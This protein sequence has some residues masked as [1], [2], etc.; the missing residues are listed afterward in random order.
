MGVNA[1]KNILK[2]FFALITIHVLFVFYI[3]N[4]MGVSIN[5]P[6]YI[7]IKMWKEIFL[8]FLLSLGVVQYTI[9]RKLIRL[10]HV[11]LV[12][13]LFIVLGIFNLMLSPNISVGLWSF[14]S[15][16]EIFGFYMLGRMFFLDLTQLKNFLIFI[17]I[18]G[19]ITSIFGVIQVKF[20]GPDFFK[21]VYG[22]DEVA[23]ALTGY[24]Y[25]SIRASSTFITPHEFG[26]FLVLCFLFSSYLF[27]EGHLKKNVFLVIILLLMVGLVLSLSR[28]S[29]V[30][31]ILCGGLYWVNNFKRL[32]L[33]LVICVIGAGFFFL[34]GAVENILSVVQGKDPSS[35]GRFAVFSEF[36]QHVKSHPFGSGLGTVGVVVRR[37]TPN[38]PQFEGEFFNLIAMTSFVGGIM[39]VATQLMSVLKLNFNFK[40]NGHKNLNRLILTIIVA[41][42]VRE[43]ILPRDFT[44]Y[45]LGWFLIGSTLSYSKSIKKLESGREKNK[46]E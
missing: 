11:D 40:D 20:L 14:R 24:G 31:A 44:N 42:L 29:L 21:E 22:M 39:Y 23:V 6:L 9:S 41:L 38:A 5:D 15:L 34:F 46:S 13:V 1:F 17:V 33:F 28:S 18:M 19:C 37:F 36:V 45:T 12:I 26:L 35:Q 32:S 8:L 43:L 3:K 10:N 4:L 30:I 25:A 7:A 16:F 27:K 2:Y